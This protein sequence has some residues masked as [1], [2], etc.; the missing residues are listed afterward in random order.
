MIAYPQT[1]GQHDFLANTHVDLIQGSVKPNIAKIRITSN[2]DSIH[3]RN[4][5]KFRSFTEQQFVCPP[6]FKAW[7]DP[8]LVKSLLGTYHIC[9]TQS[10]HRHVSFCAVHLED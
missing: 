9:Q 6:V 7:Y 5:H 1:T 2:R 10:L 3:Y 4:E 8:L